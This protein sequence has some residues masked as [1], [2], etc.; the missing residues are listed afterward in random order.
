MMF[1]LAFGVAADIS[2]DP[3]FV[4]TKTPNAAHYVYFSYVTM[5][6]VGYG[7]LTASGSAERAPWAGASRASSASSIW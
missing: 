3:F 5:A 7:D 6:T 1:A 2:G 4:Q